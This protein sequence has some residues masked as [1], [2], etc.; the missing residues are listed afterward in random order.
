MAED[1]NMKCNDARSKYLK[2]LNELKNFY[3]C[4]SEQ[5]Y[6]IKK[7]SIEYIENEINAVENNSNLFKM[8][9]EE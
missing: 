2:I 8:R 5:K 9:G 7:P 4:D 1:K 3:Q 6:F